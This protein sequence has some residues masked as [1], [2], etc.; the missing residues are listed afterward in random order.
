MES[1]SLT[2][3][4]FIVRYKDTNAT[5]QTLSA[6]SSRNTIRK[7][8]LAKDKWY[9]CSGR[10]ATHCDTIFTARGFLFAFSYTLP[11]SLSRPVGYSVIRRLSFPR[12]C[13]VVGTLSWKHSRP[14]R[15]F[16]PDNETPKR[17][18][19]RASRGCTYRDVR[20]VPE[21]RAAHVSKNKIS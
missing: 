1:R 12:N 6:K 15:I 2:Q 19:F 4:A 7:P 18:A 3:P 17:I 8:N 20:T 5:S 13:H 9:K 10:P 14:D 16:L 21:S 11:S